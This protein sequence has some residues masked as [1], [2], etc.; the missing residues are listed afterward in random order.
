MQFGEDNSDAT[1]SAVASDQQHVTGESVNSTDEQR[2]GGQEE[3]VVTVV[4]TA[5]NHLGYAAPGQAPRKREEWQQRLRSAFQQAT[6]FAV[7]Q[8]VALFIQGGDLFD[9]A[10][11]PERDRDFVAARL[12]QL[13]Q[14]NV[15]IFALGGVHDTPANTHATAGE[16]APAP[17][18]GYARLGAL[19]YFASDT[20]ELEPVIIDIHGVSVGICGFGTFSTLTGQSVD[21]LTRMHVA[22]EIERAA[23]PLLILHAPI[24]GLVASSTAQESQAQVSRESIERQTTFRT[25]LAGYHRT[26]QQVHLGQCDVVV[27]GAT[28]LVGFANAGETPGFVFLGLDRNGIRWVKHIAVDA[29][30]LCNLVIRTDELWPPHDSNAQADATNVIIAR[31]QPLCDEQTMVQLRLEGVLTRQQYHQLDLNRLRRFG[32]E[33][34]FA[35]AID[36]S[37]LELLSADE[38]KVSAE[39]SERFSPREELI[40]LAD[41]WIAAAPDEQEQK[42]LLATKEELLAAMDEIQVRM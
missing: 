4:F 37:N 26:H 34:A 31:L 40:A 10:T 32:E 16:E 19:T 7:G 27:A 14:A 23:I 22:S 42:A 20:F 24:E 21:P 28:Q 36:D 15:R 35:L 12:A 6:D 29:L 30:P 17:Q 1:Q 38:K 5:E 18:Q 13:R 39:A 9:S 3:Q 2:V 25:I 33:H 41:E 8:G 11:P